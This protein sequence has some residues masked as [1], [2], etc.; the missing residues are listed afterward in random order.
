MTSTRLAVVVPAI[1]PEPPQLTLLDSAL[2]PDKATDPSGQPLDA[3]T[4]EQMATLPAELRQELEAR[5][6]DYWLKGV[7]YAPE[8]HWPVELRDACDGSSIDLP[9]IPAPRGLTLT[10][11]A[12]GSIKAEELEYQLTGKN[13]NGETTSLAAVKITLSKEGSVKLAWTKD[14]ETAQYNVYGRA[15]GSL[16]LIATVGPFNDDQAAEWLDDGSRAPGS[17]K[18]P[19]SNTTGGGGSYSNLAPVIAIPYGM[20]AEDYCSTFGFDARDFKGRAERLLENGKYKAVEK[21]FETGALAQAKGLPNNYL[22]KEGTATNLTPGAGAPSIERG[23]EI[24]QA[25]LSEC[26]F[27]GRGMIHV[28]RQA[29]P[30]LLRTRRVGNLLLDMF[31]NIIVPGVGYTGTGPGGVEPKPGCSFIYASDMVAARVEDGCQ[32][33]TETFAEATDWSQGGEPNTI[34]MRAQ[35]F[36]I[37]YF[38]AACCFCTE[39]ELQK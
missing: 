32:V 22:T 27:G 14:N 28:Q 8:N 11:A 2:R 25:A 7:T 1:P 30:N 10:E 17:P 5:A 12:G 34:R 20:L 18:P 35:K 36:A 39:V 26:G 4:P 6:G 29:A 15:K 19:T 33:F 38:D 37:A 24:L 9:P 3:I 31:D 16:K 21:E 13:A 23:L